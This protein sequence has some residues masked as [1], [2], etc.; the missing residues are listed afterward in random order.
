MGYQLLAPVATRS[1]TVG[2]FVGLEQN[3]CM[4]SPVGTGTT[5]TV[6]DTANLEVLHPVSGLD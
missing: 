6:T 3:S 2:V 1:A 4:E 5:P